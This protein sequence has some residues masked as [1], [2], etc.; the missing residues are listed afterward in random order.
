VM[1]FILRVRVGVEWVDTFHDDKCKQANLSYCD[2]Q[3]EGFYNTMGGHGHIQVFDWGQDNAWETDFTHPDFGGDSLDWS[4]NVHFCMF[5]SHGGN[6]D[7]L[8]HIAFASQ[9]RFCLSSSDEWRL[10]AK[11]LKWIIFAGCDAV[12]GTS[13][14]QVGGVWFGPMQGVHIVMGYLGT[15]ADSWWTAGLGSDV[16]GDVCGG[17]TIATSWVDRAYSFWTGDHSIAIAAGSSQDEALNRRENETLNWRD[18]AVTSTSWLAWKW[19]S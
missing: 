2:D 5:D 13:P 17:G 1:A 9:H 16:A 6:W 19:R 18:Y 4:D 14:G 10:G 7:N 15:S 3:A 12:L 8:L 11:S